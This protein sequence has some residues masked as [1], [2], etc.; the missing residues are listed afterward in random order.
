MAWVVETCT[1]LDSLCTF[2]GSDQSLSSNCI[3]YESYPKNHRHC[4]RRSAWEYIHAVPTPRRGIGF[5]I[6]QFGVISDFHIHLRCEEDAA[7]WWWWKETVNLPT[8][9]QHLWFII[10]YQLRLSAPPYHHYTV[11]ASGHIAER[12]ASRYWTHYHSIN[13]SFLERLFSMYLPT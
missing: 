6:I 5:K 11:L 7:G 3:V 9:Q 10:L 1:A 2:T 8:L 13:E 4:Y 12:L